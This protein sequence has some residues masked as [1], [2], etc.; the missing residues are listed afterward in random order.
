[1]LAPTV[2]FAQAEAGALTVAGGGT[3]TLTVVN[4]EVPVQPAGSV[5]V[6]L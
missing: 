4:A 6:T 1:M 2:P 5:T 3:L